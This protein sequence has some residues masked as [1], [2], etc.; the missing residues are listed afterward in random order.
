MIGERLYAESIE[1]IRE[2]ANNAYDANAT[3]DPSRRPKRP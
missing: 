3:G 1:L 2:I